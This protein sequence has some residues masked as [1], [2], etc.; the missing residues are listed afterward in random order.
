MALPEVLLIRG[1]I[2]LGSAPAKTDDLCTF[3]AGLEV[4]GFLEPSVW[5]LA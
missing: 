1:S 2:A 5:V 3:A 4:A